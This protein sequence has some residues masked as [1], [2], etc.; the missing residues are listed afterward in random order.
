[1]GFIM[2]KAILA[3]VLMVLSSGSMATSG[4]NLVVIPDAVLEKCKNHEEKANCYGEEITKMK[5]DEKIQI[6]KSMNILKSMC[7]LSK[8][9]ETGEQSLT[10]KN[11]D[12]TIDILDFIGNVK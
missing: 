5:K 6:S 4:H 1:M 12:K 8:N 7:E 9:K 11:G 10:C 2:K 3:S